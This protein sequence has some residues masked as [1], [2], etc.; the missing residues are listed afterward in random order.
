MVDHKSTGPSSRRADHLR[1]HEEDFW[2]VDS[3]VVA[4]LHF[5]RDDEIRRTRRNGR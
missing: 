2:T 1:L 5:N 4:L 3:R